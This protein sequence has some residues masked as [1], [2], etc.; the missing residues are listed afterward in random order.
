MADHQSHVQLRFRGWVA[1]GVLALLVVQQAV[2]PSRAWVAVI[3]ALSLLLGLGYVWAR[4]LATQVT[5]RRELH[6][7]WVQ[8]GDLLEEVFTL[9]NDSPW[10]L[11]WA[12]VV[13][14]SNLAG[15]AVSRV[16]ATNPHSEVRWI[17]YGECRRRG[18][19]TLGPWE[20]EMSDPFGFFEI[21]QAYPGTTSLLV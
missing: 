1:T 16:A 15:Y 7:G 10:P 12:E 2:S 8:V 6:Y 14:H 13:D 17:S 5:C 9:R 4:A 19:F 20:L 21:S 3:V 18:V 11:L